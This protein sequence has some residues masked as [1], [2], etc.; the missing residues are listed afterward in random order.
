MNVCGIV[1]AIFYLKEVPEKDEIRCGEMELMNRNSIGKI[2]NQ[3]LNERKVKYS[4]IFSVNM[5]KEGLNVVLRKREYNG[6]TV[7]LSL[8]LMTILYN[9]IFAG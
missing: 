1:Y 9:G 6:R 3:S 2:E 4:E 8:F 5:L 7:V